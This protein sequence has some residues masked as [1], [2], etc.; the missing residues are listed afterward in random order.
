MFPALRALSK[1]SSEVQLWDWEGERTQVKVV[2]GWQ[3]VMSLGGDLRGARGRAAQRC[4]CVL[5]VTFE[6]RSK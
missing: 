1:M 3:A 6:Q 4:R 5:E 2:T